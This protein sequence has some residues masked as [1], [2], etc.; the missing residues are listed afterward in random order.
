MRIREH[1]LDQVAFHV[2]RTGK[3]K[4]VAAAAMLPIPI[5]ARFVGAGVID[6]VVPEFQLITNVV[7]E[8]GG[9]WAGD[10]HILRI[11]FGV[12]AEQVVTPAGK[13][14]IEPAG[15]QPAGA[16]EFVHE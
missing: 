13:T 8:S 6:L 12:F 15:G 2:W 11:V 7:V 1:R 5:V 3:T 10:G 9:E 14:R 4:I 16:M